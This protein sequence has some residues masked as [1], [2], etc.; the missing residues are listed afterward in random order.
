MLRFKDLKDALLKQFEAEKDQIDKEYHEKE[1]QI[2]VSSTI[3]IAAI[4]KKYMLQ[5]KDLQ[6]QQVTSIRELNAAHVTTLEEQRQVEFNILPIFVI[7]TFRNSKRSA[8]TKSMQAM[9]QMRSI[10]MRWWL[11]TSGS[12]EI[13]KAIISWSTS[14]K[15]DL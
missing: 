8:Q 11:A 3:A 4:E 15:S 12:W 13:S 7:N 1:T 2:K 9:R 5:V 10:S 6:E 14:L